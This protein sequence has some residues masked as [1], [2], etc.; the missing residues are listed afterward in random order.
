[1]KH[2]LFVILTVI[3]SISFAG[4]ITLVIPDHIVSMPSDCL[5]KQSLPCTFK[6]LKHQ[7]VKL[8][9]VNFVFLK[10]AVT[11]VNDFKNFNIE[12][13]KGGF[14][15]Q[16]SKKEIAVRD[17]KLSRFPSFVDYTKDQVEVVDGRDF[18]VYRVSDEGT[19]KFLYDRE[20]F[21]KKLSG[22]YTNL[23]Q[24]KAEYKSI[25][26][27]Y[28]NSFKKDVAVHKHIVS[29]KIASVE[30][31]KRLEAEREKQIREQQRRNKQTFFK[32]T[33]DQ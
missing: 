22:F 17:V 14:V 5:A 32:R 12:P 13:I 4:P 25:S 16:K 1:M 7:N 6:S 26:P 9:S 28:N 31:Q 23:A 2:F 20:S 10:N 30:E 11:K 33:F 8:N 15:I 29:R 24:F 19:E 21:I 27:I 3:A 18:Y